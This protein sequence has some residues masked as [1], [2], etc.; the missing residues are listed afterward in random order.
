[1]NHTE[2]Q[3]RKAIADLLGPAESTTQRM[4]HM[5]Q[6]SVLL[7][8]H[9]VATLLTLLDETRRDAVSVLNLVVEQTS[10]D[11]P[12]W[13]RAVQHSQYLFE[14]V[15][16]AEGAVPEVPE[17]QPVPLHASGPG[18]PAYQPPEPIPPN[19]YYH[20]CTFYQTGTNKG[21]GYDFT[22]RWLHRTADFPTGPKAPK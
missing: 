2:R 1:M 8:P 16:E 22:M 9:H 13:A 18:A 20:D 12:A 17:L 19:V 6:M 7:T 21:M 11:N 14:M 5:G 3:F 10:P 15:C 4:A